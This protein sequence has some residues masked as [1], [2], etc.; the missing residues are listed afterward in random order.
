MSSVSAMFCFYL[1]S[2]FDKI[3]GVE[4]MGAKKGLRMAA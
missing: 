4:K 2:C 3:L 1:A